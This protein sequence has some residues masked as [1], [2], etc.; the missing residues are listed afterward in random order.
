LLVGCTCS[1]VAEHGGADEQLG[2]IPSVSVV[3]SEVAG[4]SVAGL[5]CWVLPAG[6]G[7]EN[8]DPGV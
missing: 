4:I 7:V 3:P 8:L 2:F 1:P 6:C 5:Q